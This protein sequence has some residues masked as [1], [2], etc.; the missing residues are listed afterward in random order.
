MRGAAATGE[1]KVAWGK[2][3]SFLLRPAGVVLQPPGEQSKLA[4]L[5]VGV[6]PLQHHLATCH[7]KHQQHWGQKQAHWLELGED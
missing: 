3:K 1:N 5:N 6:K 2:E 7:P 4:G